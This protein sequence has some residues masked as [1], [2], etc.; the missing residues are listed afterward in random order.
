M[1][2]V[3]IHAKM[4]EQEKA[5]CPVDG[6]RFN[7]RSRVRMDREVRVINRSIE[8]ATRKRASRRSMARSLFSEEDIQFEAEEN[9]KAKLKLE[10]KNSSPKNGCREPF[11]EEAE[12]EEKKTSNPK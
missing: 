3:T 10:K 8:K 12:V 11:K 4:L 9:A 5:A 1:S 7:K 2:F 6:R